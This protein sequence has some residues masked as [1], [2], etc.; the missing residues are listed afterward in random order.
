MADLVGG[1]GDVEPLHGRWTVIEGRWVFGGVAFSIRRHH[2]VCR[3][4]VLYVGE[5]QLLMLALVVETDF[6]Q[7]RPLCGVFIAI[8]ESLDGLVDV[9]SIAVDSVHCGATQDASAVAG[10]RCSRRVVVGVEKSVEALS[11][12]LV[13][14]QKRTKDKGFEKPRGVPQMPFGGAHVGH[15]LNDLVLNAKRCCQLLAL[16]PRGSEILAKTRQ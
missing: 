8:E 2:R 1:S 12:R 9:A 7:L 3:Q 10:K 16:C 11:K 13:I 4:D 6:D 14:F 15:G 5:D